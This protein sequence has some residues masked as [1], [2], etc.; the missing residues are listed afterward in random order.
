[1][2]RFAK[3]DIIDGIE[4]MMKSKVRISR[5]AVVCVMLASAVSGAYAASSVRA[6]GGAGT[7]S[8][9]AAASG[10]SSGTAATSGAAKTSAR[11]GSLRAPTTA[12]RATTTSSGSASAR[13]AA[14]TQRLSVGKYLGGGTSSG[15][16]SIKNQKPGSVSVSS[17]PGTI[18]PGLASDWESRI[19]Y[20]EDTLNRLEP[21]VDDVYDKDTVDTMV[22]A[23]Q[24]PVSG[25][26]DYISVD[27]DEIF[28]N[29]E[30][31]KNALGTIAGADGR[32]GRDVEILA[33]DDGIWWQY[34]GDASSLHRLTTWDAIRGPKGDS[35]ELDMVAVN[36][37]VQD[38]V[39]AATADFITSTDLADYAKSSDVSS[40]IRAATDGLATVDA[41]N[42][43]A[44]ASDLAA[45]ANAA[46]VYT[47]TEAD[48]KFA[49]KA[50]AAAGVT[51][52]AVNEI[53]DGKMA[54]YAKKTEIPTVP[55]KVSAF[56]NDANYL[57]E[58]QSLA[59]LA[60]TEYVDTNLATVNGRVDTV[61]ADAASAK[62]AADNAA[63]TA[64]TAVA[65]LTSKADADA[66]YTK[67]ESDA[68]YA[69]TTDLDAKADASTVY[70]REEVDTK[71]AEA[72]IGDIDL[73]SY[74]K[75][76]YVDTELAKKAET[77]SLGALAFKNAINNDDIAD[78]AAIERKKLAAD[79]QSSLANADS[80]M[81]APDGPMPTT[82][83]YVLAVSDGTKQWFEVVVE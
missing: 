8:G 28:L 47:R 38:A 16:A 75:K 76:E 9:A 37:A 63:T 56:D 64:A 42:A 60:T 53:V 26:D 72:G 79:I 52:D 10:S 31:V 22:A 40:A 50:E 39:D 34:A 5:L 70:T 33:L 45:K 71:I 6:L 83:D 30:N 13:R 81:T 4:R 69:K 21:V 15:G 82:G 78:D 62:T 46:D 73:E 65:G 61:A 32:D 36:A 1:L 24:N 77:D 43:K 67:S 54:D 23:K 18:D 12:G 14:S 80:A 48:D 68:R 74:A 11:A 49:T 58:H 51:Q 35:A 20:V 19:Q 41:L 59:G 27:D 25:G 17:N 3:S 7:F 66:V 55:T 44:D 57:T 2:T 29:V